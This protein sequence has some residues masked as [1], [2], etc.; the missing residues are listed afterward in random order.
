MELVL[1]GQHK[2]YQSVRIS[3]EEIEN[4]SPRYVSRIT[5]AELA[6][7]IALHEAATGHPHPRASEII[8][9]GAR[10]RDPRNL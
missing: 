7:G 3:D 4:G 2:N 1:D 8:E 6:F 9:A 10:I 5:I